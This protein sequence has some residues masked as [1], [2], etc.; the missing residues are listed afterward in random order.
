MVVTA[1]TGPPAGWPVLATPKLMPTT[2]VPL[3]SQTCWEDPGSLSHWSHGGYK[4]LSPRSPTRQDLPIPWKHGKLHNPPPNK[5]MAPGVL[6]G[7]ML[8]PRSSGPAER[9][10][11]PCGLPKPCPASCLPG[12]GGHLHGLLRSAQTLVTSPCVYP[13]TGKLCFHS[14]R[15]ETLSGGLAPLHPAGEGTIPTLGS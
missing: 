6:T 10:T 4:D 3:S 7:H 11:K 2:R 15:P 9:L 13:S 14:P 12:C 1:A 5:A 8:T